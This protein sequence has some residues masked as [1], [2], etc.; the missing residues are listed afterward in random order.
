MNVFSHR[1]G[2]TKPGFFQPPVQPVTLARKRLLKIPEAISERSSKSADF[3]L[4]QPQTDTLVLPGLDSIKHKTQMRSNCAANEASI[5]GSVLA[6]RFK[7]LKA[8]DGD[9]FKAHDL[10][11]DQTVTVRQ[12][13]ATSRRTGDAWLRKIQELASVRHPHFLNVLEVISDKANCFVITEFPQGQSIKEILK[14]RSRLAVEDVLAVMTPLAGTLDFAAPFACSNNPITARWLF[15]E[16]RRSVAVDYG[17]QDSSELASSSI[18]LDLWE[19][20]RPTKNIERTLQFSKRR[21]ASPRRWAVRQAALLI[22]ELLASEKNKRK[23]ELKYWFE[24]IAGLGDAGNAILYH[25]LQGSPRFESSVYFLKRLT[26]A[27]LLTKGKLRAL[28]A[29]QTQGYPAALPNTQ[30]VIRRF[31]RDTAWL[32]LGVLALVVTATLLLGIGG[33]P[34]TGQ[35]SEHRRQA[36]E[37]SLPSSDPAIPLTVV[38]LNQRNSN[39]KSIP[40]SAPPAN[41]KGPEI[42]PEKD[43]PQRMEIAASTQTTFT[44]PAPEIDQPGVE[45]EANTTSSAH[46]QD[47]LQ[48]KRP[49]I[50]I[51]RSKSSLRPKA[52]DVKTRL[53]E[54]WHQSLM[55]SEIS[56]TRTQFLSKWERKKGGYPAEASH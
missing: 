13:L 24:P 21:G 7:I 18:K 35:I 36:A 5:V 9:G 14:E 37:N 15:T 39:G 54:L 23:R 17:P 40:Q 43:P 32:F 38:D 26:S 28:A 47:S 33:S 16:K 46:E 8:I 45:A 30:A 49:K 11:L 29:R 10:V 27:F 52:V 19:L 4:S 31:N 3:V 12:T 20:V 51:L 2:V 56:R 1:P 41:H 25:G 42:S 22:Y 44:T 6:G 48:A 50:Q 53:I 34:V 55:H